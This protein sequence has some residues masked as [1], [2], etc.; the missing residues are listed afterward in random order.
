[1]EEHGCALE[2]DVGREWKGLPASWGLWKQLVGWFMAVGT[3]L[4]W[5]F[6]GDPLAFGKKPESGLCQSQ[7]I[8]GLS[9]LGWQGGT[10]A[11]FG[12]R[13]ERKALYVHKQ[14][15]SPRECKAGSGL[16][17]QDQYGQLNWICPL[18]SVSCCSCSKC[19]ADSSSVGVRLVSNTCS[20]SRY[21][22]GGHWNILQWTG[23]VWGETCRGLGWWCGAEAV[24]CACFPPGC[25]QG[26]PWQ[27]NLFLGKKA[28]AFVVCGKSD[29]I[30]KCLER[31]GMTQVGYF[32]VP[33]AEAEGL[34]VLCNYFCCRSL[35]RAV[36]VAASLGDSR[37]THKA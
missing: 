7:C 22:T 18:S 31:A 3:D 9:Q 5:T 12:V 2:L 35:S 16:S 37:D 14:W 36:A 17:C 15:V 1:M 13:V 23:W 8:H 29:D 6:G 33:P 34:V 21:S 28:V 24:R 26:M 30:F 19:C 4:G 11:V 10:E 25:E 27:F 32:R 20:Q